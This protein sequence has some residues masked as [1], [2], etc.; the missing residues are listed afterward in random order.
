M[1]ELGANF[2][3]RRQPSTFDAKIFRLRHRS[4]I[5]SS[6]PKF[7]PS[8]QKARRLPETAAA[9]QSIEKAKDTDSVVRLYIE[10]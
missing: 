5:A 9:V 4:W 2:E 7:T 6:L 8:M 10:S 1:Y 3:R